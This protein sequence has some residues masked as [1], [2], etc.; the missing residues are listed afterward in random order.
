M[1]AFEELDGFGFDSFISAQ[2]ATKELRIRS[3]R[4]VPNLLP[5][6]A[7]AEPDLPE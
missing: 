1:R 7:A 2:R 4:V 6:S 3:P 5:P